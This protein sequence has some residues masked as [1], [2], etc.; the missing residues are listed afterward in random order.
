MS[1]IWMAAI[2]GLTQ[3]A[4]AEG[5]CEQRDG[6]E[7]RMLEGDRFLVVAELPRRGDRVRANREFLFATSRLALCEGF[8]HF[9]VVTFVEGFGRDAAAPRLG[10][11]PRGGTGHAGRPGRALVFR[12]PSNLRIEDVSGAVQLH[13]G[14]ETGSYDAQETFDRLEPIVVSYD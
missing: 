2:L 6:V 1:V 13:D 5:E 12:R 3:A 9:E 11:D 10:H 8:T 14:P 7:V 4:A